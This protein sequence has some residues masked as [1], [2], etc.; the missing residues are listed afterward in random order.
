[1]DREVERGAKRDATG[2]G[3][4][5]GS[6]PDS[7]QALR[8]FRG[9]L[10]WVDNLPIGS[11]SKKFNNYIGVLVRRTQIINPYFKF[12]ELPWSAYE[13][14]WTELMEYYCL[15]DYPGAWHYVFNIKVEAVLKQWGH[16]LKISTYDKYTQDWQRFLN[17]DE[18]VDLDH[19]TAL[20]FYWDTE[21]AQKGSTNRHSKR[22]LDHHLGSTS[23]AN[24]E[25]SYCRDTGKPIMPINLKA[26][27][28]YGTFHSTYKDEDKIKENM[29]LVDNIAAASKDAALRATQEA[30]DDP[31]VLSREENNVIAM[32]VM[33]YNNRGRFSLMGVGAQRGTSG[34]SSTASSTTSTVTTSSNRTH[35]TSTIMRVNRYLRGKIDP[36]LLM[37]LTTAMYSDL[38]PSPTSDDVF[39]HIVLCLSGKILAE[40]FGEVLDQ[41][42]LDAGAQARLA[43]GSSSG[44]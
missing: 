13:D 37:Q 26:E 33:G 42:D 21:S 12:K 19:F 39:T 20:L 34:K 2:P 4:R 28:A 30:A 24:L 35:T 3:G 14:I 32:N 16:E 27:L 5:G 29:V 43:G 23:F 7:K 8:G 22:K 6:K 11:W 31:H 40:L 25:Y 9:I 17:L 1:M 38:P 44:V 41:I 18:R 36:T 15:E 10:Q